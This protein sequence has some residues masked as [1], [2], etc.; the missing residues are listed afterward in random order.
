MVSVKAYI[1]QPT[2]WC[3]H[4][5]EIQQPPFVLSSGYAF[6]LFEP[7]N[8]FAFSY[9]ELFVYLCSMKQTINFFVVFLR[10][11]L[12]TVYNSKVSC[13]AMNRRNA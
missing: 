1:L 13:I 9:E 3:I 5:G 10:I 8:D 6:D 12:V 7:R 2:Q 11:S 4:V